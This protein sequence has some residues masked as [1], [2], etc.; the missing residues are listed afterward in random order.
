MS[1]VSVIVPSTDEEIDA[2]L[3]VPGVTVAK[4]LIARLKKEEHR[5]EELR[6]MLIEANHMCRATY[7]LS[8]G[9][10]VRHSTQEL[11]VNFGALTDCVRDSLLRQHRVILDNGGY[12]VRE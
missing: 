7:Q 11:G 6:K 5:A 1:L 4:K 3:E 12:I 8:L 10:T 2:L 9:V